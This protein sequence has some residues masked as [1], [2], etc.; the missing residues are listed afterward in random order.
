[1][2]RKYIC[3]RQGFRK[4]VPDRWE[5]S[6]DCFRRGEKRLLCDIQR[7]KIS[8]LTVAASQPPAAAAVT[9]AVASPVPVLRPISPTD[10][11]EEQVISSNSS[12]AIAHQ[13][14]RD[15]VPS[16]NPELVGE[17]ERLRKEN[18][19]LNKEL[20]QMKSL[21]NNIYV[22]MSNYGGSNNNNNNNSSNNQAESSSQ[23]QAVVKPLDLLPLKRYCDDLTIGNARPEPEAEEVVSPRLF[24]VP[25]GNKRARGSVEE[26]VKSEP[27]DQDDDEGNSGGDAAV[28]NAD[29]RWGIGPCQQRGVVSD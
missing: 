17:N 28:D 1:M 9:V 4:V 22:M 13:L 14:S 8:N 6:N 3:F 27:L 29:S 11:G 12:Q 20:S 2:L 18:M 16:T 23:Q 15:S 5:F 7:R 25:I 10:S 24:G 26:D 21:C 19:Q